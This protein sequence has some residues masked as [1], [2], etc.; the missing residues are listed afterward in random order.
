MKVN[1]KISHEVEI[2]P[3]VVIEKLIH[4]VI[5]DG[6]WIFEK[7]GKY[8]RGY[9]VSAGVHTIDREGEISLET[10]EYVKALDLV[11]DRLKC[12]ES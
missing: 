4:G 2:D 1:A 10:Y 12:N 8:Y 6:G 7:D 9:E 11:L 3:R 5:G